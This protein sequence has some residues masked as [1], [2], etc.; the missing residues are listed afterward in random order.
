MR[1]RLIGALDALEREGTLDPARRARVEARLLEALAPPRDRTGR[2][3][4]ILAALGAVLV[5]AGVLSLI[6]FHWED[7]GKPVQL[8]LI[9][10]VWLGLHAAG[11]FLAE[12]A[13]PGGFAARVRG[14]SPGIGR[15]LSAAGVLCFGGAIGLVA[16]I[17]HLSSRY[18]VAILAWWLLNVPV[19][20]WARTRTIEIVVTGIF[21]AWACLHAG[22]WGDRSLAG[23]FGWNREFAMEALLLVGLAALLAALAAA[24]ERTS[25]ANFAG[26]WRALAVLGAFAGAYL[27]SFGDPWSERTDFVGHALDL[28][29]CVP[30][31]IAAA[32]AVVLL[33]ARRREARG[34]AV[35]E[36]IAVLVTGTALALS[37][38]VAPR[39]TPLAAN[40]LLLAWI[41]AAIV[42]GVRSG[43]PG[44]INVAIAAFAVIVLTRYFEYFW[45][46]LEGA[47]A[48][49][50]TGALLLV[51]VT[52]LERRRKAWIR[53]S[54][55][56]ARSAGSA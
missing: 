11:W 1:Q 35:R 7:I 39:M 3:I 19:L 8:A 54:A 21:V 40:I 33:L 36:A 49:L 9:F 18:P 43:R 26:V 50:A 47:Y 20:L 34:A 42:R 25:I 55:S 13:P 41:V 56:V 10:A 15:A 16:Q 17:Y 30:F 23:G 53:E 12:P 29:P 6:A 37:L 5:A 14:R 22:E 28:R 38:V 46:R 24:V 45:D 52:V 51:L 27:L 2:V 32:A 48:F 4:S 31:A 44:E